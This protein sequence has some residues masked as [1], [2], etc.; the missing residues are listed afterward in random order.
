MAPANQ[1][2]LLVAPAGSHPV[3]VTDKCM[4]DNAEFIRRALDACT[5][6]DSFVGG[7]V[8]L[9]T[10]DSATVPPSTQRSV[11]AFADAI[12]GALT[13]ATESLARVFVNQTL[14]RRDALL[15]PSASV[16][17]P[18]A[19]ATLRLAPLSSSS[20]FAGRSSGREA[21]GS[22]SQF[23]PDPASGTAA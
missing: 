15:V 12:D 2:D 20:L 9:V 14:A 4:V 7:I 21:A 3:S 23:A 10:G 11:N 6:I 8:D 1:E 17:T 13:F 16:T 18:L 5:A 22:G 19:K